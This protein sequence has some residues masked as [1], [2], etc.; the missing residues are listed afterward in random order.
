MNLRT[1]YIDPATLKHLSE[2]KPWKTVA[3]YCLDLVVI[4][5]AMALCEITQSWLVWLAA[6]PVIAGR[7]HAIAGLIHEFAHYRFISDK[8]AS[9]WL[10]DIF[11]A[12]PIGTTVDGYRRNHLAHHRYTNREGDPDWEA[13]LGTRAY[14]FPQRMR[15]AVLNFLGYFIGVSSVRD[16]GMAVGRMQGDRNVSRGYLGLRGG[17]YLAV[18][19]A[20]TWFDV[21]PQ[22]LLYWIVPYV[23]FFFL[24][25]Y[26]RS[27]A[28]HFG[29]TMVPD[30]ELQGTRTVQ[31]YFW[32]YWFFCP[33]NLNYHLEHHLY[34]SVPFYN[35]PALQKALLKDNRFACD[36]HLT[37]G[38]VTGLLREVWLDSWKRKQPGEI[39]VV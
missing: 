16:M 34:P 9:D 20:V 21:W 17:Y 26:I 30:S 2:L 12:W 7:M 11:L 27:V 31:P 32:E 24:F 4:F 3:V 5:A 28:E 15:Y 8:N 14:T 36:A 1:S 39:A 23:T 18:L 10:G 25:M 6:V 38:Y 29:E 35:L 33:H 19:A 13:K 22:Y 37:H